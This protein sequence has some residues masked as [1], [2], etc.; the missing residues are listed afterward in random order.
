MGINM[1]K[2]GKVKRRKKTKK[3]RDKKTKRRDKPRWASVCV[4]NQ[5]YGRTDGQSFV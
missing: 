5:T 2:K 4:L 3:R 1:G